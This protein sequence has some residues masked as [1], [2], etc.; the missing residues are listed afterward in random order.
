MNLYLFCFIIAY[1]LDRFGRA[2]AKTI[3]THW[4]IEFELTLAVLVLTGLLQPFVMLA[5]YLPNPEGPLFLTS[6]F[7]NPANWFVKWCIG[8]PFTL[9]LEFVAWSNMVS[10]SA[11]LLPFIYVTNFLLVEL[12]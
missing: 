4:K 6:L 10:V 1:F 8:M 7:P 3:R 11:S 2:E 5:L 9:L 12:R